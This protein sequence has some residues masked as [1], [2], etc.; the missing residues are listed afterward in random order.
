[1][2][3]MISSAYFDRVMELFEERQLF[4]RQIQVIISDVDQ[5]QDQT[6]K[7]ALFPHQELQG[8]ESTMDFPYRTR[9]R[10]ANN[11]DHLSEASLCCDINSRL[12]IAVSDLALVVQDLAGLSQHSQWLLSAGSREKEAYLSANCDHLSEVSK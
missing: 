1:M 4:K 9:A 7:P 12:N 2:W 6:H 3:P 5:F 8:L 11:S 10:A